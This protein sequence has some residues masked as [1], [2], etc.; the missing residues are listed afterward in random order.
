ML[1]FALTLAAGAAWFAAPVLAT[2]CTAFDS[3]FNLYAFGI[4]GKD[5]SFG[6][7]DGTPVPTTGGR[8]PFDG[9]N[10]Q[11]F[12]SEYFNAIYFINA[13]NSQPN[14]IHI[15]DATT[16][17]WSTQQTTVPNGLDPTSMVAI[18][19][20]DTNGNLYSVEMLERKAATPDPVAWGVTNPPNFDASN[21][22]PVM[23]LA[24]NH[25]HFLDTE[26]EGLA[27]IFVIHFAYWQPEIQYYAPGNGAGTFPKKHG[28]VASFFTGDTQA[29]KKWAFVPDDLSGTYVSDI[30]SN[31]T[32]VLPGPPAS[33]GFASN[34]GGL[35]GRL[36]ASPSA[37][38]YLSPANELHYIG[39][40]Q[41]NM[42]ASAGNPW[43]KIASPELVAAAAADPTSTTSDATGTATATASGMTTSRA[44]ST[45]SGAPSAASTSK[46]TNG[47][48]S[49]NMGMGTSLVV[50]LVGFQAWLILQHHH[51][52][53]Q[54]DS[55]LSVVSVMS[56][57]KRKWDQPASGD[58]DIPSKVT[59]TEETNK[60]SEAATAAL[61][62]AK[63]AAQY[64]APGF[65]AG[66][67]SAAGSGA[68]DHKRDPFDGPFTHDIEINDLRNRYLLTKGSTQQQVSLAHSIHSETD[69]SVTTK[70]VWYPDKSKATEKDPPLYLHISAAT[71]EVLNKAIEKVNELINTD[72]GS[73][74]EDRK[75]DDRGRERVR[76]HFC[77]YYLGRR[78]LTELFFFPAH[79]KKWP[80]EKIP[81]GLETLRNFNVRRQALVSKSRAKALVISIMK[82]DVNLRS[83]CI[84]I[85]RAFLI[86]R[87]AAYIDK[88]AGVLRK[89]WSNAL[90]S[91]PT[92]CWRSFVPSTKRLG[93]DM[94]FNQMGGYDGSAAPAPPPTEAPPPPPPPPGGEA[95]P[96]PP[97]GEA[98]PPPPGGAPPPGPPGAADTQ[99]A[100]EQFKA[101]WCVSLGSPHP[102]FAF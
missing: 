21:Y 53:F 38:V 73:L 98:P 36:S 9:P 74:L 34:P 29:Q 68:L 25:I 93:L 63:I 77:V 22:K 100:Q 4:N 95:P 40:D 83:R 3:N 27:R 64:S 15:F 41:N 37:L 57:R 102:S 49:L 35:M 7:Q 16:Q 18:L 66:A 61:I 88:G 87:Y 28:Q 10:T 33:A 101:Y 99:S 30:N 1:P 42:A 24:Q 92:T 44:T 54:T 14:A 72:M 62:A 59:K 97:G 91:S 78:V 46:S 75:R 80:E 76:L 5:L 86:V 6:A 67:S 89:V 90:K 58:G 56:D 79:Q 60:A 84:S 65:E 81:V 8:P 17:T 51:H 55:N 20:H 94:Q 45:T 48:A 43:A 26:G 11:C 96:P 32:T 2:S 70:G 85:F 19:D 12:T 47:A 71:Q 50:A 13:D 52:T 69:A 23:A 39:V 82:L 31:T